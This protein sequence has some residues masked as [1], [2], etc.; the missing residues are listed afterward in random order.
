[1]CGVGTLLIVP[2]AFAHGQGLSGDAGPLWRNV[3]PDPEHEKFPA[4]VAP[5]VGAYGTRTHRG[6]QVCPPKA[7]PHKN[8]L[9]ACGL[10]SEARAGPSIVHL[11]TRC[12]TQLLNSPR[13]SLCAL[14]HL[15]ICGGTIDFKAWQFPALH[16][17]P[18]HLC[19]CGQHGTWP[20]PKALQPYGPYGPYHP[21]LLFVTRVLNRLARVPAALPG[22]VHVHDSTGVSMSP[23]RGHGVA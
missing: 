14:V 16:S 2:D 18:W 6:S 9:P 10:H 11:P 20:G 3:S 17:M 19:L 7:Y 1:M 13:M 22:C 23:T 4:A 15:P 21:Q 5:Q 8:L 12:T